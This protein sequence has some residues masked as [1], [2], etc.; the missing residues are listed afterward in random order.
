MAEET[1]F[2]F[3]QFRKF[4]GPVTLTLTSDYLEIHIVAQ[5][6]IVARPLSI[7]HIGL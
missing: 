2:D 6:H 4:H 3:G 7:S 1:D 5:S